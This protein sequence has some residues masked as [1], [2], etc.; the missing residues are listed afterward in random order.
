MFDNYYKDHKTFKYFLNQIFLLKLR[1]HPYNYFDYDEIFS[2][3]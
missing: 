3:I 2:K 1:L